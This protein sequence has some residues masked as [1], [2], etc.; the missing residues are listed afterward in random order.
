MYGYAGV[1]EDY[2]RINDLDPATESLVR[3]Y[4]VEACLLKSDSPLRTFFRALPDWQEVYSD[5]LSTVFVRRSGAANEPLPTSPVPA[6]SAA[7]DRA[8]R[9]AHRQDRTPRQKIAPPRCQ[10]F[11]MPAF[12]HVYHVCY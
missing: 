10:R 9:E 11:T 6:A 8:N 4:G 2:V 1:F 5:G 7:V 3:K 12:Y